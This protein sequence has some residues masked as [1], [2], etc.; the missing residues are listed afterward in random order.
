MG[1]GDFPITCHLHQQLP[2]AAC[3]VWLISGQFLGQLFA[4]R[5]DAMG[6]SVSGRKM[7]DTEKCR[8]REKLEALQ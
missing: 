7:N 6:C 5:A 3:P 2:M 8:T 1:T 4:W